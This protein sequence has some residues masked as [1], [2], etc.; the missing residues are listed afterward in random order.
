MKQTNQ[1]TALVIDN[2]LFVELAL[3]LARDFKKV[4]YTV[5]WVSAFPKMNNGMIGTGFDA[6]EV[7]TDVFGE[8]FD[9]I[10]LFIFPD[11]YHGPLQEHL[12]SLGKT[13]WGGRM[14][15]E[16]ELSRQG[17]K[18][19]LEELELPVGPYEI[20]KGT[21]ELRKFL[22]G[23]KDQFV[24]LNKWRGTFETFHS[25]D[26]RSV[27]PK[28]DE[29]EYLLGAFK[30]ITEFIVEEALNNKIE[31]GTDAWTVDGAY[32]SKLFSGIEVKDKGFIG[33]FTDY[34]KLPSPLTEFNEAM[35]PTLKQYG[36]R[37]FFSSEVRVGKDHQ[38]Y[39][40]DFCARAPSPPNEVYQEI[41]TNL[42]DV[43]WQGA[44][45]TVL[46]PKSNHKFGAEIL[47]H[48]SWADKNWQP[49]DFPEE[50]RDR[51]KLRNATIIDGRYYVIPQSVGLPEI[52]AVI[53]LGDTMQEAIDEAKAMAKEVTGYYI[54][55][56]EDSL[57]EAEVQIKKMDKLG[58][59]PF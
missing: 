37:G 49:V 12:V 48:S 51:V 40:I 18:E 38:P 27:E 43:I 50:L 55:V 4:Y 10:D 22:K 34:R 39:M 8:H 29:I 13:V 1:V 19:L 3:R 23:H 28:L 52:G 26:Y 15:E 21:A 9:E 47:I 17:M 54:E 16:L 36:Y 44:N 42:A 7:V 20:V 35:K 2:G 30:S 31:F 56:P 14:G 46:D 41:Y 5:P 33:L 45:G 59:S 11:V 32:P 53:G 24:K 6:I 58:L 57:D 25:P